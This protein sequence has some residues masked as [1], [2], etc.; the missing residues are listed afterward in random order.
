VQVVEAKRRRW[1]RSTAVECLTAW[2]R[3]THSLR[4]LRA[5]VVQGS[6]I[7]EVSTQRRALDA[8]R[9]ASY[10]RRC[11]QRRIASFLR[12][13]DRRCVASSLRGWHVVVHRRAA[14]A[15]MI[16]RSA[17]RLETSTL[18]A[19]ST[20]VARRV[21]ARSLI[22]RHSARRSATV[23]RGAF[24]SWVA[25][26]RRGVSVSAATRL[27]GAVA[28]RWTL[29]SVFVVWCLNV[30]ASVETRV[31]ALTVL[32]VKVSRRSLAEQYT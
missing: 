15:T 32:P 2:R 3:H 31:R 11:I 27:A 18:R 1:A 16:A 24:S 25:I 29:R 21:V 6:R 5:A 19:W 28:T 12:R 13:C 22:R 17:L 26:T 9:L 10:A 30:C 7:A 20:A 8:W 14:V 23:L 4:T